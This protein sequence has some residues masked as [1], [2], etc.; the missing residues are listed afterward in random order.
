MDYSSVVTKMK[1]ITLSIKQKV[2]ILKKVDKLGVG[3]S[4]ASDI[5][6]SREKIMKFATKALG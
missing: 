1:I 6:K 2:K 4:T 5:K 3:K